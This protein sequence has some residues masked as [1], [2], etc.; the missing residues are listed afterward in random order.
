[1][2]D[3]I[4]LVSPQFIEEKVKKIITLPG[5]IGFTARLGLL[6]GLREQELVYIKERAI[7]NDGYG[8]DCEKLHVVNCK[9]GMTII[10]IGWTRG[11]KK[12]LATILPINYWE[13]LRALSKFDYSDI[14]ATHKIMKRDVGVAYIAMRKI[15]YN[16]MRFRD[17]LSVDEAEVLAGRF[18]SVSG[19]YYVLHDPEK[20]TDKYI[21]AWNNFGIS[22]HDITA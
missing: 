3:H 17:T 21:T 16:I 18:K 4:Y 19:R 15:H 20:L 9:N 14:A 5:E 8:C 12:A 22:V 7:C 11:N 2:K 10:A 13:K 6:S 1:M